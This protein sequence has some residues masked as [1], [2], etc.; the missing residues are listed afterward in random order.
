MPSGGRQV[1]ADMRTHL[2]HR[3]AIRSE[4]VVRIPHSLRW[5]GHRCSNGFDLRFVESCTQNLSAD[6][7]VRANKT[8]RVGNTSGVGSTRRPKTAVQ[9]RAENVIVRGALGTNS[10]LTRPGG[11]RSGS[12]WPHSRSGAP[13]FDRLVGGAPE[14][15]SGMVNPSTFAILRLAR[16]LKFRRL[17]HEQI[18]RLRN[19]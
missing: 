11:V 5:G 8:A 18:T 19:E 4:I 6:P 13:L 17:L 9:P 12:E 14:K 1:Q 10:D 16:Q 2:I 15:N 7:L 3:P